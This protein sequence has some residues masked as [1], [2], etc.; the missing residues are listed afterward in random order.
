M[1]ASM[2]GQLLLQAAMGVGV[3]ALVWVIA[4][5]LHRAL[6]IPRAS[7][8]FW[9]AAWFLAVLPGPLALA[10]QALLASTAAV[11]APMLIELGELSESIGVASIA[12]QASATSPGPWLLPLLALIYLCGAGVLGLRWL[13]GLRVL[14][15]LLRQARPLPLDDLPGPLS[16]SEWRCLRGQGIDLVQVEAP[17]SPFALAWPQLRIVLPTPLMRRLDDQQL[18][19]VLRHEAEHLQHHDPQWTALLRL[20]GML[21]WFNPFIAAIARRA[22]LA[23]ELR[24]DTAAIGTKKNMRRAYAAAYL[25]TLRMSA[26][27]A[28]ACPVAAFSPQDLETHKMRIDHIVNGDARTRKHP[29]LQLMLGSFALS[30]GLGLAVVQ[31]STTLLPAGPVVFSGPIIEGRITSHYGTVR[32]NINQRAHNGIDLAAAR[33][34]PVHA[35]A[36]GVV[37]V[38]T[39]NYEPAPNYG[40]V[41]VLD[42]GDGWQTLYAHLDSVDVTVGERVAS[43]QSIGRLGST[44]QATGPHVHVEV[45]HQ[46]TR[47]DPASVIAS[48][49]ASK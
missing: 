49:V 6:R 43:G 40:S 46:G 20:G 44:G 39:T 42:H 14:R 2:L 45:H 12:A 11:P 22:C 32:P 34:T 30:G 3:A 47:V 35:P 25:E 19:M 48:P 9:L 7:R 17:I 1:S 18:M 36:G 16:S 23:A 24:C 5:V 29:L 4:L 41:I 8:G 28:L 33:G 15:R 21:L 10:L 13:R 37:L 38:A 31:A 26:N 27:R